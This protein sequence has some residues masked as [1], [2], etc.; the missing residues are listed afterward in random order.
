M[1]FVYLLAASD[2]V[3]SSLPLDP[4]LEPEPEPDP[5]PDPEL[6]PE[7]VPVPSVLLFTVF[8]LFASSFVSSAT[9]VMGFKFSS[10]S[11]N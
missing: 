7:I 2:S 10:R 3:T 11:A 9:S 6:D 4:E 8:L 5:E 1:T